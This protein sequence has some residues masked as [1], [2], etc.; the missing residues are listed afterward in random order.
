[1]EL[2][3]SAYRKEWL[4]WLKKQ[5]QGPLERQALQEDYLTLDGIS[6]LERYPVAVLYPV[7]AGAGLDAADEDFVDDLPGAEPVAN[8]GVDDTDDKS[9]QSAHISRYVP[10][11]SVGFSF[12]VPTANWCLQVGFSAACYKDMNRDESSGRFKS[13]SYQRIALGSD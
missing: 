8:N 3:F 9:A 12:F 4:D 7:I 2:D 6:P 13:L 11:S 10:P 1:M 5:L